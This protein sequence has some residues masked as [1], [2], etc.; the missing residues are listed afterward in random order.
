MRA[1]NPRRAREG[2]IMAG[3]DPKLRFHCVSVLPGPAACDAARSI[4]AEKI[5]SKSAPL[6]PLA[7]CTTPGE[8]QCSY[9]K[10]DDRRAG[11]RRS[12]ERGMRQNPWPQRERRRLGGRRGTDD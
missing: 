7:E 6:L 3:R 12:G 2:T 8:C 4:T 9:R 1:Q 10:F 5:L 11:P